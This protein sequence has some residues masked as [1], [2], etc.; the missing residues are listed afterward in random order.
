MTLWT[1]S[2]KRILSILLLGNQIIDALP[3]DFFHGQI[4]LDTI[5]IDQ[6]ERTGVVAYQLKLHMCH[7]VIDI[8]VCALRI[9]L[10]PFA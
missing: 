10:H 9:K 2:G 4:H 8:D 1:A 7:A 6:F 5:P 3:F